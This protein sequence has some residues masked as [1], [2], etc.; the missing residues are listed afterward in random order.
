M[1]FSKKFSKIMMTIDYDMFRKLPGNRDVKEPR[2]RKIINSIKKVG[3]VLNPIIVN[4]EFEVIDGQGR[5][6]AL[7]RLELP[8]YYIVVGGIGIN[9]CIAMNINQINWAMADYISSYADKGN[10]SYEHLRLLLDAFG[11]DF[12]LPVILYAVGERMESDNQKI[13]EGSFVCD[14][15]NFELAQERLSWLM[16][17][18]P[19]ISRLSGHTECYYMA[20]LFCHSDCEVVDSRLYDKMFNLQA[21]LIPVV[22]MLQALEKIEDIYN[23]HARE[24][25]YIKT[26]YKRF[27]D[28][29][30][31]WYDGKYGNKYRETMR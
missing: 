7:K 24:K 10:E 22:N 26:N 6:E 8:V 25:V 2:V 20:L 14:H 17:F 19:I 29:K 4:E 15:E 30:Y 13:K 18:T 9:E 31:A 12:K 21:T 23:D 3:Y 1:E 16:K 28:N 11:K 27:L 5:L